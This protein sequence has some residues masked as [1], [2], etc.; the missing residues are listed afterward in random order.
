MGLTFEWDE[1]KTQD[2][3]RD[4]GVSFEECCT[5]FG[6]TLSLTIDDPLHSIEDDRLVTIGFSDSG[7]ILVVVHT[8]RE[9]NIRVIS[10][11]AATPRERRAYGEGSQ[12]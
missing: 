3:L 1:Q 7:R 5:V 12:R 2:N 6:D 10:T 4:H 8:E 11:R 9:D